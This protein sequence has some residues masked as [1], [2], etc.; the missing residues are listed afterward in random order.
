MGNKQSIFQMA[1]LGLFAIFAAIGVIFLATTK[2]KDEFNPSQ[3]APIT[4]WGPPFDGG[5]FNSSFVDL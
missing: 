5:D 1:L 3:L 2:S 4:V